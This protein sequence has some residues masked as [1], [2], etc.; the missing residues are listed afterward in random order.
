[1]SI[2][3]TILLQSDVEI[4][5]LNLEYLQWLIQQFVYNSKYIYGNTF[6]VYNIHN[7]LHLPDDCEHY[8]SSLNSISCFPFE[9][10]LQGL[11]R[12]VRGKSNPVVQVA[13][14]QLEFQ[15]IFGSAAK[16]E[17]FAKISAGRKDSCFLLA[18]NA[19]AFVKD[20]YNDTYQC[21]VIKIKVNIQKMFL[22]LQCSHLYGT[23]FYILNS[24]RGDCI[25]KLLKKKN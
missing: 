8:G 21:E 7:L 9:N 24:A 12:S 19:V 1:M 2:T 15:S 16:K 10:F 18:N 23:Y 6:T 13:K 11:K 4:C 17:L 3:I 25:I 22:V 5:F 20:V 14:R